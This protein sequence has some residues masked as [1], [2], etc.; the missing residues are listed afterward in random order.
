MTKC[1]NSSITSEMTLNYRFTYDATWSRHQRPKWRKTD[2]NPISYDQKVTKLYAYDRKAVELTLETTD[3][4]SNLSNLIQCNAT[5]HLSPAK[6]NLID[7]KTS[8]TVLNYWLMG[9]FV[10]SPSWVHSDC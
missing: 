2:A 4:T 1:D 3:M 5:R 10:K 7:Y 9:C 8:A 6:L